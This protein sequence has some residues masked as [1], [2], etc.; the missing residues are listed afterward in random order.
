MS[1]SYRDLI[2]WQKAVDLVTAVYRWTATFPAD[3]RFGLTSQ[4]RRAAVSVAANIAEGQG[5]TSRREFH[6]FLSNARGSLLE[7]E[8]LIYVARNV[9]YFSQALQDEALAETDRV[10]RLVTA[11]ARSVSDGNASAA[12]AAAAAAGTTARNPKRETRN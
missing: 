8:T 12:A 2:A 1:N 7:L 10:L 5:R 11:L 4:M 9:Q 3:E 6:H